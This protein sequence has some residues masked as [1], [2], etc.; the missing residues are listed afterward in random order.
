MKL[1]YLSLLLLV[2]VF[3]SANVSAA[4]LVVENGIVTGV[5]GLKIYDY[6]G[7]PESQSKIYNGTFVDSSWDNAGIDFQTGLFA[8]SATREFTDFL[9]DGLSDTSSDSY[10]MKTGDLGILGCPADY[11]YYCYL[12]T[13]TDDWTTTYIYSDGT[14]TLKFNSSNVYFTYGEGNTA[15]YT[16]YGGGNLANSNQNYQA[17][18]Q[19]EEVSQISPVPVPAAIW[20]F[21]SAMVGLVG[22]SRRKKLQA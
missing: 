21:G 22:V 4:T 19:W 17:Y 13:A 7:A 18:I 15:S 6:V 5:T 10:K 16:T 20:L 12:G 8:A 3:S 9:N 11:D 2:S 14:E 1:R